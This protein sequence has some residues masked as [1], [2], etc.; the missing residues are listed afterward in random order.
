M[1][2]GSSRAIV[3]S[4]PATIATRRP[5]SSASIST[6]AEHG[7][8]HSLAFTTGNFH[9]PIQIKARS[10]RVTENACRKCHQDIVHDIDTRRDV[11]ATTP[12]LHPLPRRVGH[13]K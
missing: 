12:L 10:L 5:T 1:M 13:R 3:R 8:F 6:K 9:E 7:F 4:P 11:T 2:A